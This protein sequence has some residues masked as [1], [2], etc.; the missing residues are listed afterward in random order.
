M[1]YHRN[2]LF[3]HKIESLDDWDQNPTSRIGS[4]EKRWHL[5]SPFTLPNLDLDL[6]RRVRVFR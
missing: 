6:C 5:F 4:T 1:P 2:S 3:F